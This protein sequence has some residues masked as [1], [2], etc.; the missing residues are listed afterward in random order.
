MN[1]A[2]NP[3]LY[4][5]S[6]GRTGTVFLEKLLATYAPGTVTEHEPKPTREQMMM[7]NMRN[8]WGL[9]ANGLKRWFNA[10]RNRREQRAG[11][12]YIEINP[13]LCAMTDL[14]PDPARPIRVV[15]I[16]RDPS[17][18]ARSMTVFKASTKFRLIIDYIPFAK[19]YPSPRPE[20]WA[21]WSFYERNLA[22]WS[23]CNAQIAKLKIEAQAYTHLRY[24][25]LFSAD[26]ATKEAAV[27]QVFDTLDL[28]RPD[29]IDW[30]LFDTKANPAPPSST[31]FDAQAASR[32]CGHL[33]REMGYAI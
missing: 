5:L 18:W 20:G 10:A 17:S 2:Q 24:E 22:R 4:I 1:T 29:A 8:D 33:A 12:Q 32:I 27:M 25:D 14:L 28:P 9:R 31:E 13:F 7:A 15:H 16:T 23:W 26:I 3:R 6:A 21:S 11:G 19:P 30:A